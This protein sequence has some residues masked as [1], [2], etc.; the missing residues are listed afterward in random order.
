MARMV[1][2]FDISSSGHHPSYMANFTKYFISRN[3][4]VTIFFPDNERLKK[5]FILHDINP[6]LV[7]LIQF[8]P[9]YRIGK[10][11]FPVRTFKSLM[12]W[13][14]TAHALKVN[15][16]DQKP[17]FVFIA[18]L[19]QYL[20]SAGLRFLH[21]IID[22]L[23]PYTWSGVFIKPL[24]NNAEKTSLRSFVRK[25]SEIFVRRSKRSKIFVLN[26][27]YFELKHKKIENLFL[28]P[29][30]QNVQLPKVTLDIET[31]VVTRAAGRKIIGIFGHID[32]RKGLIN[33]IS[34]I[35]R[36]ELRHCYF[37]IAG[38]LSI[39]DFSQSDQLILRQFIK[40]NPANC[41]IKFGW[42]DQEDELNAYIRVSDVLLLTY[43]DYAGPSGFIVKAAYFKTPVI[44]S[45][46]HYMEYLANK[47]SLGTIVNE[48]PESLVQAIVKMTKSEHD[49]SQFAV[50]ADIFSPARFSACLDHAFDLS[51]DS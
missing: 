10:G 31:D 21:S 45:G 50:F 17:E 27:D 40:Q 41:F 42:I 29:D 20:R 32:P 49:F 7:T 37:F 18:E 48:D 36:D 11:I 22:L 25:N 30:L 43:G 16:C 26:A 51:Q 2:L 24:L 28:L 5:E 12:L 14:Q 33:L 19:D 3:I 23:F 1:A 13:R 46:G 15:F 39:D 4:R 47:Y 38:H 35:N 34:I 8:V 9:R 6:D 44:V